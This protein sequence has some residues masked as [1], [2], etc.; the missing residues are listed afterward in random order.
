MCLS[1]PSSFRG[2]TD[3]ILM[4]FG[5]ISGNSILDHPSSLTMRVVV[6]LHVRAHSQLRR[7]ISE[8]TLK[9]CTRSI[10]FQWKTQPYFFVENF[11]SKKLSTF[12]NHNFW[13]NT[14]FLKKYTQL[15]RGF[16]CSFHF[17]GLEVPKMI[18]K[19]WTKKFDHFETDLI[20]GFLCVPDVFLAVTRSLIPVSSQNCIF[21]KFHWF[22][23]QALN[24]PFG[25]S[26]PN[27][28]PL[29][30]DRFGGLGEAPR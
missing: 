12:S 11:W 17:W 2:D 14:Q 7:A 20:T 10:K 22:W 3:M 9:T 5:S 18:L 24:P 16:S 25:G 4:W 29:L 1:T 21:L 19:Q 6:F 13:R 26:A 27:A 30:D 28:R 23:E 15:W 8:T